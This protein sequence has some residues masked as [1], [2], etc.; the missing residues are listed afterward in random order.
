MSIAALCD[1]HSITHHRNARS[2]RGDYGGAKPVRTSL[3]AKRCWI[4]P[5]SGSEDDRFESSD[6][7]VTHAVYFSTDP[8][9]DVRDEFDYAFGASSTITLEVETVI[10]SGHLNRLWRVD[11]IELKK[12]SR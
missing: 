11:C 12:K 8:A 9:A 7:R 1:K 6:E 5:R 4:Q 3:G 2:N 10:N